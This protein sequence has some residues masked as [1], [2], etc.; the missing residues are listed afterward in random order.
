MLVAG[1]AGCGGNSV[2]RSLQASQLPL[3]RG[4][5]IVEQ[6][7]TCDRGANA[8]CALALVVVD[9]RLESSGALVF[10]ERH[11]LR[12][13]GWSLTEGDTGNQH[14]AEA[15]KNA[16]RVTYATA[17]GDLESIDLG[18]IKRPRPITIALDRAMF[19]RVPAMSVM[20]ETGPS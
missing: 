6:V 9:R 2:A 13:L 10:G 12:D 1:L 4:A 16:L 7:K 5:R 15:P 11:R 8:Y 14:A 19:G 3:V 20:L 18:S 17:A